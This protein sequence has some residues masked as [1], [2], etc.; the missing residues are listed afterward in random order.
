MEESSPRMSLI[1]IIGH[2]LRAAIVILGAGVV[3]GLFWKD[4]EAAEWI[5]RELYPWL[6]WAGIGFVGIIFVIL[7]P[8]A[9]FRV[10][11]LFSGMAMLIAS[12]LFGMDLWIMAACQT[13]DCGGRLSLA[14]G[15]FTVAG[16]FPISLICAFMRREWVM[17]TGW[18]VAG[19]IW[20]IIQHFSAFL[21][22]TVVE[23][24]E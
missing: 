18:I 8:L 3:I 13:Y 5:S 24:D 15:V 11:R 12:H 14:F 19:A 4:R 10:T 16:V 23:S 20:W 9:I 1:V 2:I 22:A 21:I 6:F 17:V 7:L